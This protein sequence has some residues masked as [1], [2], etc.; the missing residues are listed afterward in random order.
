MSKINII[1]REMT[2]EEFAR[3]KSGFDE[4][5]LDNGV[6]IQ[7]ADRFGFVALDGNVFMGCS[8]GLAYK[9]DQ[10]YSGW[11][12]LTDLFVEKVHRSHGVGGR[13]LRD[14]EKQIK[15]IGVKHIWTWTAGY[16]AP[17]FYQK[18]GYELFA[19]MENWYSD[20]SSRVGLR[21]E[22]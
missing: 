17:K 4:Y 6:E 13:L 1:K 8:S 21:K 22:L 18:Q 9:N 3:I 11:F 12:Y 7:S 5:T 10:K 15:T 16:E 20:G 14:L 2:S 19:E